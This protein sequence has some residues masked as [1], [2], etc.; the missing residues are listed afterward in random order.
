MLGQLMKLTPTQA[1]AD[2]TWRLASP[3]TL[4]HRMMQ[5]SVDANHSLKSNRKLYLRK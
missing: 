1:R 4:C 3:N 2:T 5:A